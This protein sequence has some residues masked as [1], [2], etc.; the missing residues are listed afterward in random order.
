VNAYKL[1]HAI[2]GSLIS[3]LYHVELPSR[4]TALLFLFALRLLPIMPGLPS[5]RCCAPRTAVAC[6]CRCSPRFRLAVKCI[7]DEIADTDTCDPRSSSITPSCIAA[8]ASA[9]SPARCV[10]ACSPRLLLEL[11]LPST[12]CIPA[13]SK[14]L[15]SSLRAALLPSPPP[16]EVSKNLHCKSYLTHAALRLR[17][18]RVDRYMLSYWPPCVVPRTVLAHSGAPA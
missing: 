10:E 6:C 5:L 18:L 4:P 9:T 1:Q 8:D 15:S 16:T 3:A 11:L 2:R 14:L 13:S 7:P 17:A 12:P